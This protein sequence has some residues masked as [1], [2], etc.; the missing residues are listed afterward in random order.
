MGDVSTVHSARGLYPISTSKGDFPV[1]SLHH[2]LKANSANGK[3]CAQLSC[4]AF[5]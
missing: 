2:E 4:L 1:L 5:K 3:N